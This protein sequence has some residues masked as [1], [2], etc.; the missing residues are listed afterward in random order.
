MSQIKQLSSLGIIVIVLAM[1]CAVFDF[2]KGI[3]LLQVGLLVNILAAVL[4]VVVWG[5]KDY[6]ETNG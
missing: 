6:G 2:W 3:E 5:K 1:G 4:H